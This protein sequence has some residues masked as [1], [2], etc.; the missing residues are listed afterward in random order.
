MSSRTSNV[1]TADVNLLVLLDNKHLVLGSQIR[2][3]Y[4]VPW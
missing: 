3:H 4:K 2:G 1:A